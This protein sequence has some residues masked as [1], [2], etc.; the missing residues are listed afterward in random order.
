MSQVIGRVSVFAGSAVVFGCLRGVGECLMPWGTALAGRAA[1]GVDN[2]EC[3]MPCGGD[4]AVRHWLIAS[5]A[6]GIA[7]VGFGAGE[8]IGEAGVY[9]KAFNGRVAYADGGRVRYL[10][11][12]CGVILLV[13][14]RGLKSALMRSLS[15]RVMGRVADGVFGGR[16]RGWFR[17]VFADRLQRGGRCVQ[18]IDAGVGGRVGA[19]FADRLQSGVRRV[20]LG[21][22]R[23]RNVYTSPCSESRRAGNLNKLL[24][25]ST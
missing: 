6:Q 16:V 5:Y 3:L 14:L 11:G 2:G 1:E 13:G 18:G 15:S 12:S 8:V 4:I 19:V 10:T 22:F 25:R 7:G 23:S 17:A 20:I 9:G 21:C 24:L